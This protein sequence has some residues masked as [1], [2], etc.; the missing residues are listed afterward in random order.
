MPV[1]SWSA[2]R[3][4]GVA[5]ARAAV[6]VVRAEHGAEEL[7]Q[8]IGRL[9]GRARG[10][11]RAERA[12][13][14]GARA[15]RAALRR[16]ARSASSHEIGASAGPSGVPVRS[17]GSRS[18]S[19]GALPGVGVAALRAQMPA[20][21]GGVGHAADAQHA[22]RAR[23]DLDP[24][25]DAAV[26]AHALRRG[27]RRGICVARSTSKSAPVGHASTQAPQ[28]THGLVVEAIVRAD[29]QRASEPRPSMP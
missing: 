16:C 23:R 8:Q 28:A 1:T 17:S 12:R 3:G 20:V 29:A 10:A 24:A 15:R 11:E 22:P 4:R 6:D 21:H 19:R 26:A 5:D 27:V 14:R 7:L 25:A 18:R 9:V 13:R 2:E